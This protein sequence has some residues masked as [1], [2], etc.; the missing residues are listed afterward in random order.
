M[1][2]IIEAV[3]EKQ[4]AAAA[5]AGRATVRLMQP[6]DMARWDAFVA[7]CPEA[8]FFH[9]AGWQT[10]IERTYGHKTWF[11]YVEQDGKIV[12]VLPLAEIKSRMFGHSLGS[13]PFCVLGGVAATSDAARPLLDD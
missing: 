12:G 6:Q 1:S 8:T 13:L 11:Y 10:V 4:A 5:V 7:A 9:R 3:Q 2:S